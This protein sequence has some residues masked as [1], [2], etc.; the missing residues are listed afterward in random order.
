MPTVTELKLLK[1]FTVEQIKHLKKR[2]KD[3]AVM[4]R[5]FGKHGTD[6]SLVIDSRQ[7][8]QFATMNI[9]NQGILIFINL[10]LLLL[11]DKI[12]SLD[13]AICFLTGRPFSFN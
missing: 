2:R 11:A 4:S 6:V 12:R 10:E 5:T 3:Y 7:F 13:I 1:K 9:Q 8:K